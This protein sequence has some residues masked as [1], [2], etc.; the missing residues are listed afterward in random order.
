MLKAYSSSRA[1]H[2]RKAKRI[3]QRSTSK[4]LSTLQEH[5]YPILVHGNGSATSDGFRSV[6]QCIEMNIPQ[7]SMRQATLAAENDYCHICELATTNQ[8]ALC[9][10]DGTEAY[11]AP[12]LA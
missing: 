3:A 10:H 11:M 4:R 8:A 12:K 2:F 1:G 9:K 5:V 6:S 7:S